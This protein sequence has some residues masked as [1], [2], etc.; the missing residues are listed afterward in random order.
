MRCRDCQ[1]PLTP[2][3]AVFLT[4]SNEPTKEPACRSC[5]ER[6]VRFGGADPGPP[7]YPPGTHERWYNDGISTEK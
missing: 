1:D 3:Q 5:Y 2:E 4:A 6:A 7:Q